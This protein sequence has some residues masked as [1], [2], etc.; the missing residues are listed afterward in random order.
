MLS[1]NNQTQ[2]LQFPDIEVDLHATLDRPA[3]VDGAVVCG[4]DA[5]QSGFRALWQNFHLVDQGVSVMSLTEYAAKRN[6]ETTPEP[7]PQP[8]RRSR[9]PIFVIQEHHASRLHYDFRLEVDGVLKSWAVPK[10]PTLDPTQK[11]LAVLVEDHPLSYARFEGEIPG[12]QYGAGTVRIWDKGTYENML[13]HTPQPQ[14]MAEG[15]DSGRIEF[16]LHGERLSG[17]FALIRMRGRGRGAKINWLLIKLRDEFA[18]PEPEALVAPPRMTTTSRRIAAGGHM[19]ARPART[20][21]ARSFTHTV[22]ILFPDA[23]ITKGEV[24]TY[25]RR[26]APRLLPFLRQRP[27]TLERLP[28]GLGNGH[29][30][31]WQKDTPP[32]YPDW[33]TRANLPSEHGKSV[34]YAVVN[35]VQSLLYLVNQGALSFHVW[36]SRLEQLDRPDFVLF[37]LDTGAA[38]FADAIKVALA[39]RAAL[40]DEGEKAFVKTSGKAG[41]HIL[42]PWQR[43][44][45]FDDA[46]SWAQKLASQVAEAMP[47]EA[48]VE[49]RK[50]RRGSRIYIDTLQN[51]RGHHVVSPYVL[52][53]VPGAPVSTPLSWSELTPTL[54]P[55]RFTLKTIFR[56]LAKLPRDPFAP[57][58]RQF[59]AKRTVA[60]R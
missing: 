24:L 25:Y 6:F 51:A 23:G 8:A 57:L 42:V 29:P 26:I 52:R 1:H 32:H 46:R 54:D 56:R 33:I 14:S 10:V 31:F 17:R 34:N 12:G 27:I 20:V 16:V 49:I 9:Q 40:Q 53:A 36:L 39:L 59:K 5:G 58:A 38:S 3:L 15:I 30:H 45:D 4:D 11:R 47:E 41:L 60:A 35:D 28:E 37:D 7:Q 18:R 48:T 13:A 50:A 22:K 2:K 19:P 43:D 55:G 21:R 44:G